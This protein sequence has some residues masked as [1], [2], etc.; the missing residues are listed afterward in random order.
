M[1]VGS[2]GATI[3]F[4]E[5]I[6]AVHDGGGKRLGDV[7]AQLAADLVDCRKLARL[8][9]LPELREA[10]H[11]AL[12]VAAGPGEGDEAGSAHVGGVDLDE[13]VDE[14]EP[15]RGDATPRSR[16]PAGSSR[17]ITSP[18]RKRIT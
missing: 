14:V 2:F 3:M 4:P 9:E 11:L 16:G 5:A 13:R 7:C 1:R 10:A 15:E 6:V 12:E 17:V 8:V 18:S